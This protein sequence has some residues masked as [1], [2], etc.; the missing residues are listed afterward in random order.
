MPVYG[1]S[2]DP[3]NGLKAAKKAKPKKTA[4]RGMRF[5]MTEP[6]TKRQKAAAVATKKT[7]RKV[8]PDAQPTKRQRNQAAMKATRAAARG[9]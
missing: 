9:Y 3:N 2:N 1:N 6:V 5:E 7:P 4:K 8:I